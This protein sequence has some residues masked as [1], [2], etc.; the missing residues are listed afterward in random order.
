KTLTRYEFAVIV[1]RAMAKEAKANAEDKALIA[2]LAEEYKA[3]LDQ[4]VDR[5]QQLEAK[6]DKVEIYGSSRIRFDEQSGAKTYNDNHVNINVKFVYHINKDWSVKTESEWQRQFNAS[7]SSTGGYNALNTSPTVQNAQAEQVYFT[8]PIGATT[9]KW[10]RFYYKPVYGLAFDTRTMGGEASYGTDVKTTISSSKTNDESALN[11]I[12]MIWQGKTGSVMAG[13][14]VIDYYGAKTRYLSVGFD[15]KVAND[16]LIT[17]AAAKSDQDTN[18]KAYLTTLQ[19][20]EADAAV[21]GSGDAFVSYRKVPENAVYYT[22]TDT[23][24]R[25]LDLNFKG[26][27]FGVD[28]VPMENSKLTAWYMIGKEIG[29]N[30]DRKVYRAQ[31]ELFF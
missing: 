9:V 4:M 12:D 26:I 20:K 22:T 30:D 15:T 27:R 19:Y 5:V 11:G 2:R 6:T 23:E 24:D 18:N 14:Q 16:F 13:Y 28:Y 1:A 10:G 21:P 7:T 31:W 3:E 8:G 17:A 29:T 25:I